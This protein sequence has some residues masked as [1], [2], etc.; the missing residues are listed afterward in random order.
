MDELIEEARAYQE[1]AHA[2]GNGMTAA[3]VESFM[4]R[5]LLHLSIEEAK[6]RV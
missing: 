3:E 2:L 5:L 4:T 1:Q 6:K